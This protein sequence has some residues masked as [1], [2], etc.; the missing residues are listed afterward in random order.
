MA[1]TITSTLFV[2]LFFISS[3]EAQVRDIGVITPHFVPAQGSGVAPA[4]YLNGPGKVVQVAA[5]GQLPRVVED[6]DDTFVQIELPGPQR[7]FV[8]ENEEQFFERVRARMKK[9]PDGG[10]V[11]FPEQQPV[12]RETYKPRSWPSRNVL[13]EP[14]YVCH[15][16]LFFEQP[17]FERVGYDLGVLQPALCLGV[18]YYDAALLPYHIWSDLRVRYECNAGKC[19]PGD[20]APFLIPRER[21]SVTGLLGQSGTMIGLGFLFP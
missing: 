13:V 21:F 14:S 18:F 10:R 2:S 3:V 7:L 4:T 20:Q 12:S 5:Q 19:L 9:Q 8:R 15:G 6:A 11:I 17:N 16:R 1:G